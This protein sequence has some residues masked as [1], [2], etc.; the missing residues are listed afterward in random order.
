MTIRYTFEQGDEDAVQV[1][2]QN[3][4]TWDVKVFHR[5]EHLMNT[6]GA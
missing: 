2:N 3:G 6:P 5:P 1:T 4:V